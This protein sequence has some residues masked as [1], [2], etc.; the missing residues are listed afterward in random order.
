MCADAYDL[1]EVR[2][3]AAK[4]GKRT[5]ALTVHAKG[6]FCS[7]N[8]LQ[9]HLMCDYCSYRRQQWT[10]RE[11]ANESTMVSMDFLD[12][13]QKMPCHPHEHSQKKQTFRKMR[14][15]CFSSF[16]TIRS[17]CRKLI[18]LYICV[19]CLIVF[20]CAQA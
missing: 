19:D 9:L 16:F 7:T 3:A 11:I 18:V 4:D 20:W 17:E 6:V 13:H 1:P 2:P 8:R 5:T 12:V 10:H 15:D 14:F